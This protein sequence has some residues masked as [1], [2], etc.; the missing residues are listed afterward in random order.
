MNLFLVKIPKG[1]EGERVKT[2]TRL[3]DSKDS[4]TQ[5]QCTTRRSLDICQ[6]QS[7]F[8]LS[9][10]SPLDLWLKTSVYELVKTCISKHYGKLL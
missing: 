6:A 4:T 9:P 8:T 2:P 1:E 7:G 3:T 10:S 5:I